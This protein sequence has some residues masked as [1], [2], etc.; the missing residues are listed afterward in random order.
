MFEALEQAGLISHGKPNLRVI[1]SLPFSRLIDTADTIASSLNSPEAHRVASPYVHSAS[2]G[3]GGA[4]AECQHSRCRLRKIDSLARFAGLYSD[5]VIVDN[6]FADYASVAGHAPE[7]DSEDFRRRVA[8]DVTVALSVRP[9]IDA[10][11][12]QFFSPAILHGS[13]HICMDCLAKRIFGSPGHRRFKKAF[14]H[15]S[16]QFLASIS[17]KVY[18]ENGCYHLDCSLP[19]ELFGH[20]GIVYFGESADEL[21]TIPRILSR[22]DKGEHVKLSTYAC[23]R[24]AIHRRVASIPIQSILYHASVANALSTSFLTHRQLDIDLLHSIGNDPITLRRNQML[25]EHF[26]LMLPFA[27]DVPVKQLLKLRKREEEAF[28]RFQAAMHRTVAQIRSQK[29]SMTD[30]DAR[31]LYGDLIRPRLA[32]LDQKVRKLSAISCATPP[33]TSLEPW[34]YWA[35]AFSPGRLRPNFK[36]S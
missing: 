32:E 3:L 12:I 7:R 21:T 2:L 23:R 9:L 27:E 26:Q 29:G 10:G 6:F 17:V 30:Q 35:W 19:K 33:R 28:F 1:A 5:G 4:P 18:Y 13:E 8:D 14:D 25:Q 22:V 31:I 11:L 36:P 34:Q 16:E 20:G 15:L 24:I